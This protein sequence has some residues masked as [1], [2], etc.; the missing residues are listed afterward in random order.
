[1]SER[2]GEWVGGWVGEVAPRGVLWAPLEDFCYVSKCR[3]LLPLSGSLRLQNAPSLRLLCCFFIAPLSLVS[4][5]DVI[6]STTV[7]F[8]VSFVVTLFSLSVSRYL[9]SPLAPTTI[10]TIIIIKQAAITCA[11][12]RV[13]QCCLYL[14][15]GKTAAVIALERGADWNRYVCLLLLV[16]AGADLEGVDLHHKSDVSNISCC[17]TL[18]PVQRN[19]EVFLQ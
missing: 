11:I 12:N 17:L 2:V 6:S 7:S 1:M 5:A 13:W 10:L 14:Q 9:S 19:L 18:F 8:V 15:E 3:L 16:A 4:L